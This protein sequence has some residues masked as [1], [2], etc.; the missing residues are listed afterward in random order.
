[1]AT[2]VVDL[3]EPY[4]PLEPAFFPDTEEEL[5][6]R[7]QA[8]LDRAYALIAEAG[9]VVYEDLAARYWALH[10]SFSALYL[11]KANNPGSASMDDLGSVSTAKDQ[12]DAFK[13]QAD[14]FAAQF[15]ILVPA[16]D[17]VTTVPSRASRAIPTRVRW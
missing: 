17:A 3:L 15:Y 10:L 11:Q 2:E 7:L 13:E 4:G 5:T 12:R 8:Y 1:M 9:S 14:Y 16:T 6:V